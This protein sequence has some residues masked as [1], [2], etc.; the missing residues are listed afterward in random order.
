MMLAIELAVVDISVFWQ[1][2]LVMRCF[3]HWI[4]PDDEE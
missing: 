4:G 2:S 3:V 1:C